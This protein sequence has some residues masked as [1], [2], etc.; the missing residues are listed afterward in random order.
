MQRIREMPFPT[1]RA[2]NAAGFIV[3]AG[4]LAYALYAEHVLGLAPCPLCIFQRVAVIVA[5]ILFLI[6]A[7]HNPGPVGARVY[8]ALLGLAALGGVLIAARHILIQAQPPGTVAA[9]GADL[10]YLLDIMPVTEVVTKVLTGSG[11]CGK[12]DWT[13][14]GLSMP[15]WVLISLVAL[16]AWAVAANFFGDAARKRSAVSN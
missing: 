14:L 8:G 15:W 11:E 1:R 3:C 10:D 13:L 2:A 7:L 5:G 6:A 4:L 12:V 9:C 16:G